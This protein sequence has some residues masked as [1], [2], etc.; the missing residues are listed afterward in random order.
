ML[1]LYNPQEPLLFN[2][3]LFLCLFT[4]FS[5][6][7]ALLSGRRMEAW[8]MLYV[9]AFAY[10]FYYKN[11]GPYCAILASST[12]I[13]YFSVKRMAACRTQV[14]R[15]RWLIATVGLLLAQLGFFKYTNFL[16]HDVMPLFGL[17]ART[18]DIFVPLGI[19]FFTFQSI[20]YIVDVY[21]R[22]CPPARSLAD[23]AFFVSFFPT[24]LSGPILRARTF[25][26][27]LH[28]PLTVSRAMVGTGLWFIVQGLFK[29]AIISDYIGINFV[30]RIFDNP[31]LYT[32]LENLL[33]VY[34][35]A[36]KLYC[37]FSGYSDIAIGL[38]LW[39]G[40]HI[41][42]NFRAPYKAV[43]V[44]DFWRRWHISLSTW[45]RDYLY[46]PLG[47]NRHGRLRMYMAQMTTMVLGGLWH[48]ATWNFLVWGALHGCALCVH[49]AWQRLIGHDRHYMPHGLRRTAAIIITFHVVCITWIFCACADI[50]RPI[51]IFEAI[52][53]RFHADL[54]EQFVMGYPMVTILIVTG[55]IL[56]YL[57]SAWNERIATWA[58]RAPIAVQV[59][60]L[61]LIIMLVVQ[62]RSSEVQPFIYLQF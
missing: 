58:G 14:A 44:T 39:M 55:F 20:S 8:R 41:P 60:A 43:S 4:L 61:V 10:Y 11:A 18:F 12:L 19:S 52:F 56:H 45:L 3:G 27:Q 37:D 28:R 46:I 53:T 2:T 54:L 9:T 49:K 7:Y 34:G 13:I 22:D 17:E 47:G 31:E 38:A 59:A 29:K 33:G 6:G 48:G 25:L 15:R 57:P 30:D 42:D 36:L 21:R 50:E 26:P 62:V 16:A 40:F 35:Y 5:A 51:A 32:G 1:F 23:L 24:L